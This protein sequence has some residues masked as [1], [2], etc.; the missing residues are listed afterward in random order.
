M[1]YIKVKDKENLI[2]DV[3]SNAILNTDTESY[4]AYIENYKRTY[5]KTKKIKDLEQEVSDLKNDI[6]EIKTMLRNFIK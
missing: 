6:S 4:R 2:R 3:N 1:E 5:E